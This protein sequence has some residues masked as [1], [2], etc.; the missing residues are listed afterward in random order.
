MQLAEF[1]ATD[2]TPLSPADQPA[3]FQS[4][5]AV[6]LAQR[7]IG[8]LGVISPSRIHADYS[9]LYGFQNYR[10][11]EHLFYWVGC[12]IAHQPWIQNMPTSEK[13]TTNVL[14]KWQ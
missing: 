7:A 8:C 13:K 9:L 5:A 2:H 4:T 11:Q 14:L 10:F 1:H 3:S 12:S 6:F